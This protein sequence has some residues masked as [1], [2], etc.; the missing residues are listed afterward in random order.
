SRLAAE[1]E[2]ARQ[3]VP[4]NV[5]REQVAVDSQRVHEVDAASVEVLRSELSAK[6]EYEQIS[7][8]LEKVLA[9]IEA[10]KA[11][12][13]AFA[14]SVGDALSKANMNLYGDPKMLGT[15]LD[16]FAKAAG[17]S[18]WADG[19]VRTMPEGAIE[20]AAATLSSA[21]PKL[22]GVIDSVMAEHKEAGDAKEAERSGREKAAQ[23]SGA[24]MADA[25]ETDTES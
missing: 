12:G 14:G 8:E 11:V 2:Q 22:G 3:M 24:E 19:L 5:N 16:S 23:A 18:A 6:A 7:V 20:T 13:V 10:R 9:D 25:P 17:V 4:V 21:F 1:G 15:A